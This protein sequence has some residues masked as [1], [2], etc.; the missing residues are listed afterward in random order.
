MSHEKYQAYRNHYRGIFLQSFKDQNVIP[1]LRCNKNSKWIVPYV[2]PHTFESLDPHSISKDRVRP[3]RT[4]S[5]FS[6]SFSFSPCRLWRKLVGNN[7]INTKEPLELQTSA[8]LGRFHR[9]VSGL[10]VRQ[11]ESNG[12]LLNSPSYSFML[13]L[14]RTLPK[15]T[16]IV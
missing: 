15:V 5:L 4:S 16:S 1:M 8:H 14:Y 2:A 6:L 3:K 7:V 11:Y 12:P 9:Q 13:S 10:R